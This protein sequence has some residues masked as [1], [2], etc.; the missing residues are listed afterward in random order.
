[1]DWVWV[2]IPL[3]ALSIPIIAIISSVIG[4]YIKVQERQADLMTEEFMSEM[5]ALREA[6][7]EQRELNEQR[8]ARLEAMAKSK[9]E[10]NQQA[11]AL[12]VAEERYPM[13]DL[14]KSEDLS[15]AEKAA[16]LAE[17]LKT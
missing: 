11:P 8:F 12:P 5:I 9:G 14:T 1:M 15:D 16:I 6:F 4:K 17:K 7:E 2:L 10:Q 3:T 13:P